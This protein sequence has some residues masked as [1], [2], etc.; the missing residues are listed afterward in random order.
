ME[1]TL[2]DIGVEPDELD[3]ILVHALL[4]A[5]S[6]NLCSAAEGNNQCSPYAL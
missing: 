6:D 5:E 1:S 2:T 3:S 4:E